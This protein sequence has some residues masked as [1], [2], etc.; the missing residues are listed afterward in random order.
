MIGRW[1]RVSLLASLCLFQAVAK[2]QNVD[3][4]RA[5]YILELPSN[6]QRIIP[7]IRI[8]PGSSS[9]TPTAYGAEWGDVFGGV[10]FQARMRYVSDTLPLRRK[11]DGA[12][13]FGFGLG[14]SE[15][16]IGIE[17]NFTSFSTVRSGFFHHSS[18]SFKIH[19]ELP[20]NMAIAYGWEDAIRTKGTDGGNSMYGVLTAGIPLRDDYDA[21]FSRLTVTAGAGNGRFQKEQDFYAG[22]NHLNPFGSLGLRII[23]A[24]SFIADWTGQDLM[25]GASIVPFARIP[26]FI[27]PSFA[28]ITGS[29]GDGARFVMGAGLDFDFTKR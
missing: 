29:A 13:D 4:I 24:M 11:A 10:G 15:S 26:F 18:F 14:N 27:T 21:P 5:S 3:S 9:G 1:A 28:D 8:S 17:V 16:A 22:R 7:S 19:R 23:P 12:A 6:A 2:A 20:W 25:L